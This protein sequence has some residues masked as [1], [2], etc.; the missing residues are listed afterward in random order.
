MTLDLSRFALVEKDIARAFD[1]MRHEFH[2]G[3]PGAETI[4]EA[5]VRILLVVLW[6]HVAIPN[7]SVAHPAGAAQALRAFRQL[8]EMHFRDRWHVS[9][10][11]AQLGVTRD[12][13]HDICKRSLAKP[14]LRLIHER[15]V[16]EAEALLLRS[17]LTIDQ[18]ADFLGFPST[19][20]FSRF[21]RRMMGQPPGAFRRNSTYGK[22]KDHGTQVRSFADWP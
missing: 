12:R 8:V 6:R 4:I 21:F 20:H 11:A 1:A 18:I 9:D 19:P 7:E 2:S 13:L 3:A 10:Y 5:E 22:G 16:S 15:S 14:P 17:S